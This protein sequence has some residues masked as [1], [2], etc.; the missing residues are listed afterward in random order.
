MKM[1]APLVASLEPHGA[2]LLPYSNVGHDIA[3]DL[4]ADRLVAVTRVRAPR[5]GDAPAA[6][7]VHRVAGV[8]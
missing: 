3:Q 4:R 8:P 2:L 5:P 7:R 6:V 1:I